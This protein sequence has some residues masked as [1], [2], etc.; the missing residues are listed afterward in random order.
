VVNAQNIPAD[1]RKC[2]FTTTD[3]Q[4]VTLDWGDVEEAMI[5]HE[6]KRLTVRT[7]AGCAGQPVSHTNAMAS[8]LFNLGVQNGG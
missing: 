5:R 1:L 7:L 3:K 2:L 8:E 4:E 6:V